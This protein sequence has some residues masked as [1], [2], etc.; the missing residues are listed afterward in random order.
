MSF[1]CFALVLS[2]YC[3]T[4]VEATN[5]TTTATII[6]TSHFADATDRNAAP[7]IPI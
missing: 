5:D 3:D 4:A 6:P 1:V 2:T 7:L